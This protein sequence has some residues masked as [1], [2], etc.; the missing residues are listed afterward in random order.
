MKRDATETLVACVVEFLDICSFKMDVHVSEHRV[1]TSVEMKVPLFKTDTRHS[2]LKYSL[3]PVGKR[4][5]CLILVH[6]VTFYRWC[7][8]TRDKMP[9]NS[10]IIFNFNQ[11]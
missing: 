6:L 10:L 1:R 7:M 9:S 2:I 11:D 3:R 8:I 4:Y 5:K